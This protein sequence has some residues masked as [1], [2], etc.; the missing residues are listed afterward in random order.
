L[1]LPQDPNTGKTKI[2]THRITFNVK[3]GEYTSAPNSLLFNLVKPAN[4]KLGLGREFINT[5]PLVPT[6][7]IQIPA[8]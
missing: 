2:P 4:G 1:A 6:D 5:V 8:E 7:Y 3:K